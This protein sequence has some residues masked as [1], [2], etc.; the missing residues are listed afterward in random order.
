MTTSCFFY[1]RTK[2]LSERISE[3]DRTVYISSPVECALNPTY[4]KERLTDACTLDST[5]MQKLTNTVG[6]TNTKTTANTSPT[7]LTY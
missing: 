4:M 6:F 5:S 7:S 2:H 3:F 1:A